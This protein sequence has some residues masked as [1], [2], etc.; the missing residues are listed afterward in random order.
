ML[1]CLP[2]KFV[3]RLHEGYLN[4]DVDVTRCVFLHLLARAVFESQ[5]HREQRRTVSPKYCLLV[6]EVPVVKKARFWGRRPEKY[7][8]QEPGT[9][10]QNSQPTGN[11]EEPEPPR[12]RTKFTRESRNPDEQEPNQAKDSTHTQAGPGAHRAEEPGKQETQER[13]QGRPDP[14]FTRSVFGTAPVFL[15]LHRF[16]RSLG[17]SPHPSKSSFR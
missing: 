5:Q 8:R 16:F 17:R 3:L 7:P 11:P 13:A 9:R 15:P 6:A 4:R 2:L 14:R 12:Q 10:R 1:V